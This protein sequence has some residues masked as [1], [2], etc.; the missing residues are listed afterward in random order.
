MDVRLQPP[1]KKDT[2]KVNLNDAVYYYPTRLC[3]NDCSGK[4]TCVVGRCTCFNGYHGDFCQYKN[5]H[6][7][8][9]YIDID[10]INEQS[11]VHCSQHGKCINGT[12]VCDADYI[13][14]DCSER[15]C[16]NN[17][18]NTLN[19]ITGEWDINGQCIE[20]FPLKLCSCDQNKK[21]A[22]DDC[23]L[24][25]C[26]NECSN[27]GECIQGE[28]K[29]FDMYSGLDCSVFTVLMVQEARFIAISAF[30]V[31]IPLAFI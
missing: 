18:S 30:V 16:K 12:C 26:L 21:R 6:N 28:C 27:H 15:W 19:A 5:C 20:A 22:G 8:L 31:L 7:S 13:G 11:S 3:V 24:L 10:T 23:S 1:F 4:G 14:V 25:Y 17:C 9:V 29:C 2:R